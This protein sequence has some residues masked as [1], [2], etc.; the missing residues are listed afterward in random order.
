MDK[1]E[2]GVVAA[3]NTVHSDDGQA[4]A[5]V[6]FTLDLIFFCC[7]HSEAGLLELRDRVISVLPPGRLKPLLP[8]RPH[9]DEPEW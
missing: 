2:A 9:A 5:L 6:L 1:N 3:V 7:L 4:V 8:V